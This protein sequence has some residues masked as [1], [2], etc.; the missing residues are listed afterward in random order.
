MKIYKCS[1]KKVHW[2]D[3]VEWGKT[4]ISFLVLTVLFFLFFYFGVGNSTNL[5]RA[6]STS[7]LISYFIGI[8]LILH[9]CIDNRIEIYAILEDNL[10][11]VIPHKFSSEY[12][13]SL[14]SYDDFKK[15]TNSEDKIKE[16]LDNLSNFTGIDVYKI[17]SINSLKI[18]NK[19]FNFIAKGEVSKWQPKGGIFFVKK[20]NLI[21]DTFRKKFIVPCDYKKYNELL[22]YIKNR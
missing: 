3:K 17:D 7:L 10:Y 6:L 5:E 21:K 20:Y 9:D 13:D 22:Q 11:V 16:I 15:M 2:F 14:I 8:A 1:E 4:I 18:K 12:D 19:S